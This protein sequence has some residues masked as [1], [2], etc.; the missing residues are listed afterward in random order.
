MIVRNIYVSNKELFVDNLLRELIKQE[1]SYVL[2]DNE[3]H[4][5]NYIIRFMENCSKIIR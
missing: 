2:I 4:F 5:S 3:L 1:I